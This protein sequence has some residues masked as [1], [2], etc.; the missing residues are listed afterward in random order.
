[1]SK[2]QPDP[3]PIIDYFVHLFSVQSFDEPK[4]IEEEELVLHSAPDAPEKI[5]EIKLRK[6]ETWK[7]RRMSIRQL[8]ETVESKSICYKVIY[9]D[10]LVVKIPPRPIT[11]FQTYLKSID[12]E[13]SIVN[14]VS[15]SITCV[16]PHLGA[17]MKKVPA[18][19]LAADISEN[20]AEK[21]YIQILTEKPALQQYLKIG[22][23]FVF[24][25]AL[26]KYLFFN[27]VI[28]AMHAGGDKVKEEIQTNGPTALSDI[29]AFESLYGTGNDAVFFGLNTLL[30][31]YENR[32]DELCNNYPDGPYIPGYKKKEWFFASLAGEPADMGEESLPPGF[33][34]G[35]DRMTK[36]LLAGQ[37]E[38]T[39]QYRHTVASV[40]RKKAFDVNRARS[41]GLITNVIDMMDRL[42]EHCVA[43]RDLKPDNMFIAKQ[44]D[45]ADHI[46]AKP[47]EY[48]L[49]LIDL[50]TSLC[51]KAGQGD[52]LP[53]PLLAGTPSY[54]TP[55]HLFS[56]RILKRLYG[57]DLSRIFYMQDWYACVGMIFNVVT[58][59]L[60][61]A[62]TARLVPEI[63]R[64]KKASAR[65]K[66]IITNVFKNISWRFWDS[67]II[68]FRRK[69]TKYQEQFEGIGIDLP[70]HLI[71]LLIEE[72]ALEQQIIGQSLNALLA[73]NRSLERYRKQII[74]APY[75]AI[76][77]NRK[78]W[79]ESRVHPEVPAKVREK[80]VHT[81]LAME[82][83]KQ[84]R[85]NL[86]TAI[87]RLS[88][89]IPCNFLLSYLFDRTF[90]AM[91]RHEWS[92]R[93][94]PLAGCLTHD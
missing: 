20:E 52:E 12:R 22:E 60:L 57:D 59:R 66:D 69:I 78:Q 54:A 39:E 91:Y 86:N 49:G 16:Y 64:I 90:Y 82:P 84:Q 6:G 15:K 45:G 40:I 26:S 32:V 10:M 18:T 1:M 38:H 11:D 56:N 79:Q 88:G 4:S 92:D 47:D 85:E 44:L 23:S 19:H 37:K 93:E 55:S 25:M 73:S 76:V 2:K 50:E 8:G 71:E 27:Q 7:T 21:Q 65:K 46:L 29:D 41:R 68:E 33:G 72:A 94:P 53:Q 87:G 63:I 43:I 30:R 74:A 3:Q 83:L 17:I 75:S 62:K 31:D 36:K 67:A 35:V 13:L 9:D 28:E 89:R 77:K 34:D 61:F 42:K 80:I 14:Q 81:F 51:F 5:Y 58:G 70:D 48:K 24:F